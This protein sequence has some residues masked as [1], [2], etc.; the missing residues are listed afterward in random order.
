MTAGGSLYFPIRLRCADLA[1]L[2]RNPDLGG[3]ITRALGRS[4]GRVRAALPPDV[5][6]AEGVLLRRAQITS[7]V[8]LD[9][10]ERKAL[11]SVIDEAISNA[12]RAQSLPLATQM[13]DSSGEPFAGTPAADEPQA[14][15]ADRGEGEEIAPERYDDLASLY[16]LPSYQG[17]KAH[18]RVK[19][20]SDPFEKLVDLLWLA[21]ATTDE[22]REFGEITD[23]N[24][25]RFA[26]LGKLLDVWRDLRV[27]AVA[28][29]TLRRIYLGELDPSKLTEDDRKQLRRLR[30]LFDQAGRLNLAAVPARIKQ[31]EA[32]L[33][34]AATIR[35]HVS[36][37]N[38]RLKTL[39]DPQKKYVREAT[40]DVGTYYL[41]AYSLPQDPADARAA[42]VESA[43]ARVAFLD[44]FYADSSRI[45][46]YAILRWAR[47]TYRDSLQPN[48]PKSISG[49]GTSS[50]IYRCHL[51]A[52]ERARRIEFM[53]G[54][55]Y[56]M[57]RYGDLPRSQ[58]DIVSIPDTDLLTTLSAEVL[59]LEIELPVLQLWRA[60]ETLR[61][62]PDTTDP[63]G[64]SS[65]DRENWG[66]EL[67]AFALRFA[68]QVQQRNHDDFIRDAEAI[69]KRIRELDKAIHEAIRNAKIRRM[70]VEQILLTLVTGGVAAGVGSWVL[71][72]T[73]GSRWL[74]LFAEAA[75]LT[76]V[77]GVLTPA[78]QRP[79]SILGWAAQFGEN[80]LLA[81]VGQAIGALARAGGEVAGGLATVRRILAFG[82]VIGANSFLQ[83]AVQAIDAK[84]RNLEGESSFTEMLSINL[85]MN[86]IGVAVGAA[87]HTR[88]PG[89]SEAAFAALPTSEQLA[90]LKESW[91]IPD[92]DAQR[93]L[94][95]KN[96][97]QDF[98]S[99]YQR[100][101]KAA[102]S[103]KLTPEEFEAWRKEGLDLARDL[104]DNADIVGRLGNLES[105]QALTDLVAR[106]TD[107]LRRV[108]YSG[109]VRPVPELTEGLKHV[110]EGPTYTFDPAK[111]PKR[112]R[113]LREFYE[114]NPDPDITVEPL[115]NNGWEA[116]RGGTIVFQA[117]PAGP[118]IAGLLPPAIEVIATN[119]ASAKGLARITAGEADPTIRAGWEGPAAPREVP[120]LRSQLAFASVE[121]PEAVRRLLE[122]AGR[123][124]LPLSKG[125][126]E[127]ISNYLKLGGET[128]TL[129]RAA[130]IHDYNQRPAEAR[131]HAERVLNNLAGWDKSAVQG[132]ELML[133]EVRTRTPTTS[134]VRGSLERLFG[135]VDPQIIKG[136]MQAVTVLAPRSRGLGKALTG[137]LSGNP[138][139]ERGGIG[140]LLSGVE[141]AQRYPG[142][143]I[144]FEV[145][146]ETP[147]GF[148]RVQDIAVVD[149]NTGRALFN[150]EIKEVSTVQLGRRAS[151]EFAVDIL[152]DIEAR[153]AEAAAGVK[154]TDRYGSFR[155]R[156]R[157]LNLRE[158]AVEQLKREGSA[159]PTEADVETRMRE[160]VQQNLRKAFTDHA[161]ATVD[162]AELKAYQDAFDHLS[163]VEF[164]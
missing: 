11:L 151:H 2:P 33:I 75:T 157:K 43:P 102:Q 120:E 95:L 91:K 163:F 147:Q 79:S 86:S 139:N 124:D 103:G 112:L 47:S 18:V 65:E 16:E 129:A 117:L 20:K 8:A 144:S 59:Q 148:R 152:L 123:G 106:M 13:R 50:L 17:G 22:I 30:W 92:N 4:F 150:F 113:A 142:T 28:V 55:L 60:A 121:S 7:E 146:V 114:N 34:L 160:Y 77:N 41:E 153:K 71:R 3:A 108:Q 44:N 156:I 52:L 39:N 99:R 12:A 53:L 66:K 83:T 116:K 118:E 135:D 38:A 21:V 76:V 138:Y 49:T 101:A 158:I 15:A 141:L 74:A 130:I 58:S 89:V 162:P 145:P 96:R 115:P 51:I 72:V 45:E 132:L 48:L 134:D 125:A 154:L 94:N 32:G 127:G 80:L 35:A 161:L 97:A 31:I 164:F 61:G 143:I 81:R 29:E 78:A 67:D 70:I 26:A 25:Q 85:L 100:L 69:E 98:E 87:V 73:S 82:G 110:G 68:Q 56:G 119:A 42:G 128:E 136:A 36:E 64:G 6:F 63:P 27:Q 54:G 149:P 155:W 109:P 159:S 5:A 1:A 10:Y 9:D 93:W 57:D 14:P 137:L 24:T 37:L 133:N 46:I 88:R 90:Q 84:A 62:L 140:S 107:V 126:L 122:L 23:A 105:R 111:P 19:P 131:A 104:T 40:M